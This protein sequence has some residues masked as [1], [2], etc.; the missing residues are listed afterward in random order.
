MAASGAEP[1]CA[2]NALDCRSSKCVV[3]CASRGGMEQASAAEDRLL[4]VL[5]Q[6]EAK[7]GSALGAF[8]DARPVQDEVR[9]LS[10]VGHLAMAPAVPVH[11]H[12]P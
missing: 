3:C 7:V 8:S 1:A 4:T 11:A 9:L 10:C 6:V 2:F 12:A 5:K